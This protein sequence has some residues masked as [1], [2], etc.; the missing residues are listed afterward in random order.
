MLIIEDEMLAAFDIQGTLKPAGATLFA[1]ADSEQEALDE[2]RRRRPR[3]I[4]P[5]S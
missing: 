2:A 5:G 4:R 1:F 3:L